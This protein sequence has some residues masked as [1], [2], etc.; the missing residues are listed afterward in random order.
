MWY[1]HKSTLL[2]SEGRMGVCSAQANLWA[3]LG[4]RQGHARRLWLPLPALR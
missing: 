2:P 4:V 3:V 1:R